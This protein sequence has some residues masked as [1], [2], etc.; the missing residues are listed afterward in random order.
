M[1]RQL[2]IALLTT[3]WVAVFGSLHSAY[4]DSN[5]AGATTLG[6]VTTSGSIAVGSYS[7]PTLGLYLAFAS[8][9]TDLVGSDTNGVADV[10]LNYDPPG[11]SLVPALFSPR[12]FG[13]Q[14]NGPSSEPSLAAGPGPVS[15]SDV[16]V[17]SSKASDIVTDT[18]GVQDV[19]L[20]FLDAN[21]PVVYPLFERLSVSSTGAQA[22]GPS[23]QPSVGCGSVL[24]G[25]VTVAF[26]SSATNLVP[27]DSNRTADV[28]VR[29]GT[30]TV[31]ASVATDE[32]QADTGA[33]T[34]PAV[35]C[36]GHL[37]AFTSQASDL[38]EGDGNATSDVFVRDLGA[39]TTERVSVSNAG[40]QSDGASSEPAVSEDGRFVAFTSTDP[41]LAGAATAAAAQIYIR[42]RV[43]GTTRRVS[44]STA[45][46]P[47]N[48]SSSQPAMSL[49]G[50]YVAFTSAAS[51]LVPGD[52][53]GRTDVFLRDVT[54]GLTTRV[55]V[56]S[57][58]QQSRSDSHSP[59]LNGDGS[60]IAFLSEAHGGLVPGD[61]SQT[62]L[63]R[64]PQAPPTPFGDFD[65]DG[66]SDVI[67]RSGSGELRLFRGSGA[68]LAPPLRIGASGWA[69]MS[70]ITRHGDFDLDGRED[71]IARE[72]ATGTLWLYPG[73][74]TYFAPRIR[75]GASGWNG[76]REITAVGDLTADGKPDLVA[77]QSNTGDLY[78]YPGRGTGFAARRILGHGGWNSMDELTGVGDYSG[79]ELYPG[80]D[81]TSTSW[82]G[83]GQP[84]SCG[85]TAA[86]RQGHH[87]GPVS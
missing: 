87:S 7:R 66:L 50:R 84:D 75:I 8:T 35:S 12:D 1:R 42:D 15:P 21:T 38:V 20:A 48:G 68:G 45:G 44:A 25:G 51:N 39:R 9:A 40:G 32:G 36:D 16:V 37:V 79:D 49:N 57:S 63:L 28:F 29:N 78:L 23:S 3:P 81:G 62:V 77:V 43:A 69:G 19:F 2:A 53:N 58:G 72:K 59:A 10:F 13:P 83:S 60:S 27:G 17:F 80:G 70:A 54:A 33:S 11:E 31:R 65:G 24:A 74:R 67:A 18:N 34:Q 22:N 26:T 6:S 82:P 76:M 61:T 56:S 14:F 55:S 52:T 41:D 73:R 86:P 4:A 5:D 85:S 71:V 64:R 46:Q 30:G 47:G